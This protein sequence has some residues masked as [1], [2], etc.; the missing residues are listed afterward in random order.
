[1]GEIMDAVETAIEDVRSRHR[2]DPA[3]NLEELTQ[4]TSKAI[5][6]HESQLPEGIR[7]MISGKVRHPQCVIT[8][9]HPAHKMWSS[10]VAGYECGGRGRY[11]TDG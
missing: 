1:M 10:T 9:E 3:E 4:G 11:P 8:K 6:F 5:R 2:M 7:A